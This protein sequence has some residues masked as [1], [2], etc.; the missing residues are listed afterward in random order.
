MADENPEEINSES[1]APGKRS[2]EELDRVQREHEFVDER[3]K[4]SVG[5]DEVLD[6]GE[7][8]EGKGQGGVKTLQR[9]PTKRAKVVPKKD[10][11]QTKVQGKKITNFFGK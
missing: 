1:R 5:E 4:V 7:G 10:G 2:I 9:K 6:G 8:K 11:R 3:V